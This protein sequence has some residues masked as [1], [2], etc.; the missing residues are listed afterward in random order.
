MEAA[1]AFD[2]LTDRPLAP[3]PPLLHYYLLRV[4]MLKFVLRLGSD[5][6]CPQPR[7]RARGRTQIG[8]H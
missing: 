8:G 4:P 6:G 3:P 1:G 2:D 5:V 7:S